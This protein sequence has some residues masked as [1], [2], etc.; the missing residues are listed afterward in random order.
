MSGRQIEIDVEVHRMIEQHRASFDERENDILRRLLLTAVA[1]QEERTVKARRARARAGTKR[2]RGNWSVTVEGEHMPA[3]NL[4][5]AYYVLLK[6]L[7]TQFP[8]FLEAFGKEQSRNRRFVAEVPEQLY[9]NSSHLA[10]GFACTLVDGWYY[11]SNLSSDQ[12]SRRAR[13]AARLCG[14]NYGTDVKIAD[15]L[16][17]I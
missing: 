15:G 17:E 11:D 13:I 12:I 2:T 6:H 8:G 9:G 5:D 16:R 14:L 10:R 3:A 4:G 1:E 7:A